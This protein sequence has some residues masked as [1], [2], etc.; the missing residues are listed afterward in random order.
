LLVGGA[1]LCLLAAL[2]DVGR[3]RKWL[4]ARGRQRTDSTSVLAR[5][6]AVNR[7]ESGG[8][9]LRSVLNPLAVVA[10]QWGQTHCP[11]AWVRRYGSRSEEYHLPQDK[12]ERHAYAEVM[13]A[14]GHA[15]LAALSHPQTPSWLRHLPAVETLRQVWRH[16]FYQEAGQV[17][18]RT[19]Q[20]GMPPAA[21]LINAPYDMEARYAKKHTTSWVGYKVHG[22]ETCDDEGPHLMTHVETT[23]GPVADSEVTAR[24]H[25]ALEGTGLWPHTHIVDTGYVDA[26]LLVASRRDYGVDLLGPTRADSHWQAR[27][28]S[29]FEA[30]RFHLDWEQQQATCPNGNLSASW[31]SAIKPRN[32]E[33]V[34]IQ[35]SKA[36][37]QPGANRADCTR[38]QR[39][40]LTV[41]PQ[42]YY[43]ALQA[44]R[45]REAS[46]DYQAEYA[47]RAGIEGPISQ[48]VRAYGLRRARYVGEAKTSLQHAVTAAAINFVRM[49]NWLMGKPLAKTRTSAFER[50]MK[51]FALC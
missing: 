31:T 30:S 23:A 28:G 34:T 3:A 32:Q 12:A 37:C 17:R 46:P 40:T 44:A 42:V 14:D 7:L 22:T 36:D 26:T 50:V 16:Q 15:L 25:Q 38:A 35:C 21:Q 6:R 49:G 39:R 45:E 9:T 47:R 43:E 1:E 33:V 8:E 19:E 5:V 24:M 51:Q 4:K 18:W 20:E 2:L 10:P 41:R 48:G 13:G 27:A 11:A 29:G